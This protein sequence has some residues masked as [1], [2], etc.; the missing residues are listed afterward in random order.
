[1]ENFLETILEY[2]RAE[3]ETLKNS[4]I[5]SKEELYE[6]K[7]VSLI[8]NI[9]K[10]GKVGIIAEVKKGSPSKGLFA[11]KLDIINQAIN[12]EKYGASCISVLTDSKF[13]YGSFDY[14]AMI[15][16][17]VSLPLLC[18]DFIIDEIQI[19]KAKICGADLILLIVA[20][21]KEEDLIRLYRYAEELGLE[22]L[23]EVH[24]EIELEKAIK[25]GAK[26]IGVNNRNLKSF[27]VDLMT[28][29]ELAKKLKDK[30]VTIISESGIKNIKDAEM[31]AKSGVSGFLIGEALVTSKNLEEVFKEMEVSKVSC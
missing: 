24:N 7:T 27:Q 16:K 26:L 21:L 5:F 25:L 23:V 10:K 12:Y 2:K 15:R 8:K 17:N 28:T 22:V 4:F 20:A 29:V 18:K 14:L 19:Q 31:L 11:P 13:F 30:K 9:N 3:I 6:R 1:M